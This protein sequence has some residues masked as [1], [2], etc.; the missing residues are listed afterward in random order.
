MIARYLRNY[1]HQPPG[2]ICGCV[3]LID[4]TAIAPILTCTSHSAHAMIR[5][6]YCLPYISSDAGDLRCEYVVS[7]GWIVQRRTTS[8]SLLGSWW[9]ICVAFPQNRLDTGGRGARTMSGVVQIILR[10]I[11]A[12]ADLGEALDV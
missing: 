3:P 12:P 5:D 10:G 1:R 4:G 6:S 11:T 2:M 9:L 7:R 8:A